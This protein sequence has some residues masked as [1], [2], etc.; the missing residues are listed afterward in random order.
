MNDIIEFKDDKSITGSNELSISGSRD[1]IE[2]LGGSSIF[3]KK[4]NKKQFNIKSSCS[5]VVDDEKAN[6]NICFSPKT[7]DRIRNLMEKETNKKYI[8]DIDLISA[9]MKYYL[10]SSNIRG[11]SS[12]MDHSISSMDLLD[13]P[14]I[15]NL[16]GTE[17]ELNKE[18]LRF[19]PKGPWDG[20][21]LNNFNIDNYLERLA[22][23]YSKDNSYN[24]SGYVFYHIPFVMDD[25]IN[26][27]PFD[28]FNL[29]Q[30]IHTDYE[31]NIVNLYKKGYNTFNVVFNTDKSTGGGKHWYSVF[32]DLSTKGTDNN[33]WTIEHFN[34]SGN[35][36]IGNLSRK[37]VAEW[38][39]GLKSFIEQ[40]LKKKV[41]I[42]ENPYEKQK[43]NYSCGVYSIFYPTMRLEGYS[44]K[45]ITSHNNTDRLMDEF[46][47]RAFDCDSR[48]C[49]LN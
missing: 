27:A 21:L 32:I 10:G 46:K 13:V 9:T 31:N 1:I 4:N 39:L 16:I 44:I 28:N 48:S 2:N 11:S 22:A 5:V 7:L 40:N 47:K 35:K 38:M 34:S 20:T 18:L 42:W 24:K 37:N 25:L 15:K 23:K 3:N 49:P 14:E 26:P 8:N 43:D 17:E 33:P 19:K 41:I 6:Q 30:Y 36:A 45:D 29:K 12:I